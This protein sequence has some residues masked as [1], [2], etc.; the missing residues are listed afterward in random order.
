VEGIDLKF[1]NQLSIEFSN[2]PKLLHKLNLMES[3]ISTKQ[4]VLKAS[5]LV[6]ATWKQTA[7]EMDV[8]QVKDYIQGI[9]TVHSDELMYTVMSTSN[10]K[11]EED[12]KPWDMKP[13]LL[14]GP[15]ARH[16]KNSVYNIIPFIHKTKT[17]ENEGVLKAAQQLEQSYTEAKTAERQ[18]KYRWRGRLSGSQV[19]DIRK[20]KSTPVGEYTWKAPKHQG[21]VRMKGDVGTNQKY[22]TYLTFR[23][24]SSNS[25]PA[26]WW[27]PGRKG[28]KIRQMVIDKVSDNVKAILTQAIIND[29]NNIISV[30]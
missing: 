23:V 30:K 2:I 16:G 20:A 15:K 10:I 18:V 8:P 26:S 21:L 17:L 29:V 24:V 28:N 25:D 27:N 14:G 4:A 6:E 13:M 5:Q 7:A 12:V 11:V 22:S 3:F 1:T 19:P 9:K